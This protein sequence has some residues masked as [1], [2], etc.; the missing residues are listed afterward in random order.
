MLDLWGSISANEK[1]K[2]KKER[3]VRSGEIAEP[4]QCVQNEHKDLNLI[5][6]PILKIPGVTAWAEGPRAREIGTS[7]FL[8]LNGQSA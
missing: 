7:K 6:K 5:P 2:K 1:K 4:E 8:R 3:K